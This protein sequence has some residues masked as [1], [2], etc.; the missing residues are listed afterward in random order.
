MSIISE[1]LDVGKFIAN[2][3]NDIKERKEFEDKLLR[4]SKSFAESV[5]NT[6]DLAKEANELKEENKSLREQMC[7]LLAEKAN[8]YQR[9]N[10]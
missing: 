8:N 1:V 3:I 4:L 10:P 7:N 2:Q 5:Q 6:S 9:R